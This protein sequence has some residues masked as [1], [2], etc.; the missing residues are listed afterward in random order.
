MNE[1]CVRHKQIFCFLVETIEDPNVSNLVE[2]LNGN[3]TLLVKKRTEERK[4]R[5]EQVQR[6]EDE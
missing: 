3:A 1:S 4:T 2:I 6:S 5:L